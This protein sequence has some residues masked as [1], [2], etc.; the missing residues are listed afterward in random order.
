MATLG[1]GHET[2]E[3][4]CWTGMETVWN[5]PR[6]S[7]SRHGTGHRALKLTEAPLFKNMSLSSGAA[8][9]AE[10]PRLKH[11]ASLPSAT[12]PLSPQTA[13]CPSAQLSMQ[14]KKKPPLAK[15]LHESTQREEGET[16]RL[17]S[18]P[19]PL[20]HDPDFI[21]RQKRLF[22][23]HHHKGNGT[24]GLCRSCW[25]DSRGS[26]FM[27]SALMRQP[28]ITAWL[29]LSYIKVSCYLPTH[30]LLI[31][32]GYGAVS[33]CVPISVCVCVCVQ[34]LEV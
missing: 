14:K 17:P 29:P 26:V 22:N 4:T 28:L 31:Q 33:S 18:A 25:F 19:G 8:L 15:A 23:I 13:P 24:P 7:R 3:V 10:T 21:S 27:Q 11:K 5:R 20:Q 1:P 34:H 9:S 16:T 2:V 6:R 32:A 30:A 12:T